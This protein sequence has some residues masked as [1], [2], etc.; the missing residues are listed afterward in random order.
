LKQGV[1]SVKNGDRVFA[2]RR[3]AVTTWII[4]YCLTIEGDYR[5]PNS[6]IIA[7]K[8]G[9]NEDVMLFIKSL[10]GS[11]KTLSKLRVQAK[12]LFEQGNTGLQV[13]KTVKANAAKPQIVQEL[14]KV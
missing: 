11:Q 5:V 12:R 8:G 2:L 14:F 13:A 7:L 4:K 1:Y 10:S 6:C 3:Q 9:M